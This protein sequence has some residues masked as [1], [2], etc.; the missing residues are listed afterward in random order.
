MYRDEFIIN[1]NRMWVQTDI[2]MLLKFKPEKFGQIM[3]SITT[4]GQRLEG[5]QD[6]QLQGVLTQFVQCPFTFCTGYVWVWTACS[7]LIVSTSFNDHLRNKKQPPSQIKSSSGPK[8]ENLFI[9]EWPWV[10][11]SSPIFV[12]ILE[13]R[14]ELTAKNH[15]C[16]PPA[17]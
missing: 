7:A 11:F 14:N 9:A 2:R 10:D 6:E 15:F 17:F 8:Y 1:A 4:G 12:F 5:S 3:Q 16:T 13:N